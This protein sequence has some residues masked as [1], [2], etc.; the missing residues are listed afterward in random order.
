M[1]IGISGKPFI[2]HIFGTY[3]SISLMLH[4]VVEIPTVGSI[5]IIVAQDIVPYHR[6]DMVS[7]ITGKIYSGSNIQSV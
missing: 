2:R 3:E 6:T 5:I 1:E 7:V 4:S